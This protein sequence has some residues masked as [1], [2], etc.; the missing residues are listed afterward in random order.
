MSLSHMLQHYTHATRDPRYLAFVRI[1]V[2]CAALLAGL[3]T[4][5]VLWRISRPGLIVLPV[6]PWVPR[7]EPGLIAPLATTWLIC[8]VL[9]TIGLWARAA[10]L[11]LAGVIGYLLLSDQQVY[12]NH[13]YLLGL[14]VLLTALGACGAAW[15]LEARGRAPVVAVPGWPALLVQLQIT[16]VYLFGGLS[17]L[18]ATYLSGAVL[19]AQ[20]GILAGVE[21]LPG[22]PGTWLVILATGSIAVELLIAVGLWLPRWRVM[23]VLLGALLHGTIIVTMGDSLA[24]AWQLTVFALTITAPYALFFAPPAR[25]TSAGA[26]T[27]APHRP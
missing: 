2:G 10:G 7:L 6:L 17:K 25:P 24:S 1:V 8:A 18:N 14:V 20:P 23:A 5:G 16:A 15:S 4:Y 13:L 27:L 21:R 26:A 11:T 19:A 12:S 9:F 22:A 3:E